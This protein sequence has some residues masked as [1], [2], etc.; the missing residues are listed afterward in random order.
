MLMINVYSLLLYNVLI[1]LNLLIL[2]FIVFFNY[3]SLLF[4]FCFLCD[5]VLFNNL[6]VGDNFMDVLYIRFLL[7]FLECFSLLCRCLS[8][9]LRLFCNLLSSHFLLLMFFDFFYFFMLFIFFIF[10]FLTYC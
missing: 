5:F 1:H 4:L 2:F 6:L 3:M 8:L 10:I 9:F 7:C